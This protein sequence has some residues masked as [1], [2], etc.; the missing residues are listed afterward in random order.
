MTSPK[1]RALVLGGGGSAGNA[2]L[3]GV[4]AG[5]QQGG[6]DLT[7]ADLIIGTSAGATVGAQLAASTPPELVASVLAEQ[8]PPRPQ[9]ANPAGL[10]PVGDYRQRTRDLVAASTGLADLRKRQGAYALALEGTTDPARQEHWRATVAARL[11]SSEWPARPLWITA[12]DAET[13]EPVTFT[14]D[15]GVELV[16]AVAASCAGGFAFGIGGRHYIDGGYRRSSENADL[17]AGHAKVVVLSPLGG[18][19]LLPA[20]WRV[21]L[22]AQVAELSAAASEVEVVLP[23]SD[24]L[25]AFG[26]NMMNAAARPASAAAGAAQGRGLAVTLTAFWSDAAE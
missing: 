23:D 14:K 26:D 8:A 6:V 12:V 10:P 4:L 17:A 13:G 1:S 9:A 25:A 22:A 20:Q 21:D 15:S 5:L 2:W 3:L 24:A 19:S 16:D 11:P 7:T 18:R